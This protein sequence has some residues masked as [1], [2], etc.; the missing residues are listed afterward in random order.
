MGRKRAIAPFMPRCMVHR[1]P[2]VVCL[3]VRWSVGPS[4]HP[5]MKCAYAIKIGSKAKMNELSSQETSWLT[6]YV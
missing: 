3:C 1:R 5:F 2:T 6:G 4:I